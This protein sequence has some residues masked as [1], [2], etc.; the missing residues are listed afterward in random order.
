M[1]TY[2]YIKPH[3]RN[4]PQAVHD[5]PEWALASIE[6]TTSS[7]SPGASGKLIRI[8]YDSE[9]GLSTAWINCSISLYTE[10]E[11]SSYRKARYLHAIAMDG[12]N[13]TRLDAA[14]AQRL[15]EEVYGTKI[16]LGIGSQQRIFGQ[17]IHPADQN[18]ATGLFARTAK[19]RRA[20]EVTQKTTSATSTKPS[21]S[22]S[23]LLTFQTPNPASLP[24]LEQADS[25]HDVDPDPEAMEEQST[26][27]HTEG[28]E[29][30][31]PP[32][33]RLESTEPNEPPETD[34][35]L[36]TL[37][38][39]A[40]SRSRPTG[41]W[42][43]AAG[44]LVLGI[45]MGAAIGLPLSPRHPPEQPQHQAL[46]SQIESYQ[47]RIAQFERE[48]AAVQKKLEDSAARSATDTAAPPAEEIP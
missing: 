7:A 36:T 40:S 24:D 42:A 26:H 15:F 13:G 37:D 38:T 2:N 1:A 45:I 47:A 27:A 17:L 11:A 23:S 8:E 39:P 25:A 4:G 44:L 22:I 18:V 34:E 41:R 12:E 28:L 16:A 29:T 10:D 20:N 43:V 6:R 32:I 19:P 31:P 5:A 46:T 33:P 48:L 30:A 21:T 3:W 35:A 9:A 14:L